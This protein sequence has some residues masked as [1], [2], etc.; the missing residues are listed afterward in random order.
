MEGGPKNKRN[1]E[2]DKRKGG[3]RPYQQK[4]EQPKRV[5][6][7]KPA[8]V[9]E[10]SPFNV[11]TEPDLHK[12]H[13]VAQKILHKA[14]P[15]IPVRIEPPA[16]ASEADKK[17]YDREQKEADFDRVEDLKLT[18]SYEYA[19]SLRPPELRA[20]EA[21]SHA[22]SQILEAMLL[23]GGT[24]LFGEKSTVLPA[25]FSDRKDATDVVVDLGNGVALAIDAATEQDLDGYVQKDGTRSKGLEEK[26]MRSY[27]H[28]ASDFGNLVQVRYVGDAETVGK[29]DNM[30]R[31]VLGLSQ[32]TIGRLAPQWAAN[33]REFDPRA[34]DAFR[35]LKRSAAKQLL[36]QIELAE[37]EERR[38][39]PAKKHAEAK[40]IRR[41]LAAF[42]EKVDGRGA[43]PAVF[44]PVAARID[45][46][47]TN[48]N[49]RQKIIADAKKRQAELHQGFAAVAADRPKNDAGETYGKVDVPETAPLTP[50][51]TVA[52]QKHLHEVVEAGKRGEMQKALDEFLA[53]DPATK[54]VFPKEY[55]AAV[56]A[57]VPTR[58][59][60]RL[61]ES[62][63][64]PI[65]PRTLVAPVM[66][67]PAPAPS[68]AEIP[69]QPAETIHESLP[70][71]AAPLA[72][73]LAAL[74]TQGGRFETRW[75][76]LR[77]RIKNGFYTT[78]T[79]VAAMAGAK[80]VGLLLCALGAGTIGAL[81][82]GILA[83][84]G[85]GLGL[86]HFLHKKGY[87]DNAF[88]REKAGA[89]L[90]VLRDIEK[91][92]RAKARFNSPEKVDAEIERRARVRNR[93]NTAVL[94][95]GSGALSWGAVEW[96]TGGRFTKTLLE[97]PWGD[98]V[99]NALA[100]FACA[101]P[102]S[103]GH[104]GST[105]PAPSSLRQTGFNGLTTGPEQLANPGTANRGSGIRFVQ[106][107]GV[108]DPWARQNRYDPANPWGSWQ[109]R[110]IPTE[111]RPSYTHGA[112]LTAHE[113]AMAR[114]TPG[115]FMGLRAQM[116]ANVPLIQTQ[117]SGY[118][119][120]STSGSLQQT[121]GFPRRW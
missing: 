85:V 105:V 116:H 60:K 83:A 70:M 24:K 92:P 89:R 107:E 31:V 6:P 28:I 101:A 43:P 52:W 40:T 80:S 106:K 118:W 71:P 111:F 84:F 102:L 69:A 57:G 66:P 35:Q 1:N 63:H 121:L 29:K 25:Q 72:A 96:N 26:M 87:M 58:L 110:S 44:D 48:R 74:Q 68:P 37:E 7:E 2:R 19:A 36:S 112:S 67:A 100:L 41:V 21:R 47:V 49:I 78:L 34:H 79:S 81:G 42:N 93:I 113:I 13:L 82:G 76:R 39:K 10:T 109:K 51:E 75:G 33:P 54:L 99:H 20:K 115:G 65:T 59:Y 3:D 64:G 104:G 17:K 95:A 97:S 4:R 15:E 30:P 32:E 8:F 103:R 23:T 86:R 114:Q 77:S 50:L 119:N 120:S 73:H 55:L 117:G 27:Q 108:L 61:Y 46:V 91:S 14:R 12:A 53:K 90:A 62:I 98:K 88:E 9:P 56:A 38:N 16:G 11:E 94:L 5:Q 45:A 18:A 22:F